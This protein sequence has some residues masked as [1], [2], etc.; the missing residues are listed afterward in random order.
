MARACL[1]D[2]RP[3]L[4]TGLRGS[5][6]YRESTLE[7]RLGVMAAF[8]YAVEYVADTKRQEIAAAIHDIA[9]TR[10]AAGWRLSHI[11]ARTETQ[12]ATIGYWLTFERES[13][14]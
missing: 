5:S 3:L 11:T 14:P 10:G 9:R 13:I 4:G 6:I 1:R 12:G 7:R 8:Q 2:L